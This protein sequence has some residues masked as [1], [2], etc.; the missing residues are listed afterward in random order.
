MKTDLHFVEVRSVYDFILAGKSRFTVVNEKTGNSFTYHVVKAEGSDVWFVRVAVSY[1]KYQYAGFLAKNGESLKYVQGNRGCFSEDVQSVKAL[2][3]V[4]DRSR[5]GL[6][7]D[8]VHVL[9]H[10]KCGK[11]GRV[12]TDP[13]SIAVGLGPIC[14]GL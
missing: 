8:F 11:C 7:P 1:E 2:L 5:R 13:V 12:L 14:R 10:G 3:F 4:L 9:H 6:L